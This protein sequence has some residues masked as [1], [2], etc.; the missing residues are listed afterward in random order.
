MAIRMPTRDVILSALDEVMTA[1]DEHRAPARL[2]NVFYRSGRPTPGALMLG[3]GDLR[4]G[5]AA[6]T[7]IG[8]ARRSQQVATG[9]GSG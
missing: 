9:K 5:A 4:D 3:N 1:G 7:F 6:V 2:T 8:V